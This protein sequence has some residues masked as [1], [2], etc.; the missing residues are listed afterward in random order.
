MPETPETFESLLAKGWKLMLEIRKQRIRKTRACYAIAHRKG[1]KG[2]GELRL[3]LDQ[4]EELSFHMALNREKI[5]E[6]LEQAEDIIR[7]LDIQIP[8]DYLRS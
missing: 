1:V 8:E 5:E 6:L 4:I 2:L 7:E 3:I